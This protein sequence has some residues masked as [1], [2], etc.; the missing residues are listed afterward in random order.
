MASRSSPRTAGL[1]AAG[2]EGGRSRPSGSARHP[3]RRPPAPSRSSRPGCTPRSAHRVARRRDTRRRPGARQWAG[4]QAGAAL[5]GVRSVR[6]RAATRDR[7]GLAA[8][9]GRRP[10]RWHHRFGDRAREAVRRAVLGLEE[11]HANGRRN[12]P[13]GVTTRMR[14]SARPWPR[15]MFAVDSPPTSSGHRCGQRPARRRSR[16]RSVCAPAGRRPA[17]PPRHGRGRRR[18]RAAEGRRRPSRSLRSGDRLKN[19]SVITAADP[20]SMSSVE[21]PRNVTLSPDPSAAG[22]SNGRGAGRWSGRPS[23][24]RMAGTLPPPTERA[25]AWVTLTASGRTF[26]ASMRPQ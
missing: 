9:V 2:R 16:G 18:P 3:G 24:S 12:G 4:N 1:A 15:P 5:G 17:G 6:S 25:A 22:T 10:D 21:T 11:G 23:F 19:P 8:P 26:R 7:P 13:A 20:S 14:S